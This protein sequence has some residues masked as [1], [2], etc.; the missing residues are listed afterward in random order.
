M[1]INIICGF[2]IGLL[3]SLF[4]IDIKGIIKNRNR[5]LIEIDAASMVI[6]KFRDSFMDATI[7]NM[8]QF[9]SD[10][11]K[12]YDFIPL[13]AEERSK[14]SPLEPGDEYTN[15]DGILHTNSTNYFLFVNDNEL[16]ALFMLKHP[17]HIIKVHRRK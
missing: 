13:N 10:L 16:L 11:Y 9:L 15:E 7:E 17:E 2:L 14:L 4:F 6:D 1:V 12:E 8:N 3:I 5:V